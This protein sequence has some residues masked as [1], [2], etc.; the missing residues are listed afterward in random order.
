MRFCRG[1]EVVLAAGLFASAFFAAP[2]SSKAETWSEHH[3]AQQ[4]QQQNVPYQRVRPVPQPVATAPV[5]PPEQQGE[6][7]LL[8]QS[9]LEL[10][11]HVGH[12]R[13]QENVVSDDEEFMHLSG[14]RG[15]IGGIATQTF[16][17]GIFLTGDAR[18]TYGQNTYVGS[19]THDGEDDFVWDVRG[20]VGKDF[21]IG[22]ESGLAGGRFTIAPYVGV[23]YRN[24]FNDGRGLT[25]TGAAGYRRMSEYLYLPVGVTPRFRLDAETRLASN[26]EFDYIL[27]GT[28]TSYLSDFTPIY[29]DI[30]NTQHGGY[31]LRGDLM[32]EKANWSIGPY[33]QYWNVPQSSIDVFYDTLGGGHAGDEPH[34]Y[35]LEYGL[36]GTYRFMWDDLSGVLFR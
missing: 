11:A 2:S 10:E 32:L 22:D 24:L 25:S 36:R 13:Y 20:L 4:E 5:V 9:G 16:E 19:G 7:S 23:G 27:R 31:G 30:E 17:H 33:V 35:T 14:F 26:L 12:Y 6:I 15:G 18:F 3:R 34:N 29:P 8:T 28:Q 21:V 1:Q